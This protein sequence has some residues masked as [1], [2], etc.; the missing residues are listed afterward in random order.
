MNDHYEFCFF[1]FVGEVID[2]FYFPFLIIIGFV[3]NT[4]SFLVRVFDFAS[5]K[6][7]SAHQSHSVCE[8]KPVL[9]KYVH[10]PKR[11]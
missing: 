1:F 9:N 6:R 7:N 10:K 2:T 3:G 11:T 8:P 5:M 4:L